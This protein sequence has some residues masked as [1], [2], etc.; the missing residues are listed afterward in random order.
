MRVQLAAGHGGGLVASFWVRSILLE[1]IQVAQTE[2][3]EVK[4]IKAD[5]IEGKSQEYTVTDGVLKLGSRIYVPAGDNLRQE[6]MEEAHNSPYA[7][8]PGSTKM[9]HEVKGCYTWK[10]IQ[11][12]ELACH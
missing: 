2:D 6:I 8:H 1:R 7:M 4:Q 12:K 9:Y 5:L 10:V 3:P 11:K